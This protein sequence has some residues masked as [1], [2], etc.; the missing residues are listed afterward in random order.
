MCEK[1]S[2]D[3]DA[4]GRDERRVG[5]RKMRLGGQLGTWPGRDH[6]LTLRTVATYWRVPADGQHDLHHLLGRH[7]QTAGRDVMAV[8]STGTSGGVHC[9]QRGLRV[10]TKVYQW[11][12]AVLSR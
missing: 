8:L 12:W 1:T 11:G 5:Q 9:P 10:W 7:L 3:N 6:G 2:K 4:V